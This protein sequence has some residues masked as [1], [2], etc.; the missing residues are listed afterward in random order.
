M[1][2]ELP[3]FSYGSLVLFSW[4][5]LQCFVHNNSSMLINL[6]VGRS[7]NPSNSSNPPGSGAFF[8]HAC[9]QGVPPTFSLS[10]CSSHGIVVW[11]SICQ[12]W[13]TLPVC[14]FFTCGHG[15]EHLVGNALPHEGPEMQS[16]VSASVWNYNNLVYSGIRVLAG[17]T[18]QDKQQHLWSLEDDIMGEVLATQAEPS[19]RAR[20][21]GRDL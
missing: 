10:G 21:S 17:C 20:H 3:A 16:R 8:R 1:A 7:A 9:F 5:A 13:D 11:C 19:K 4:Q 6:F 2:T 14:P 12:R 15:S 18:Q